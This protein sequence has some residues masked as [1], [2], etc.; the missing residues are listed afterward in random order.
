MGKKKFLKIDEK[1]HKT[2]NFHKNTTPA[3]IKITQGLTRKEI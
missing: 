2:Q 3:Q 1:L